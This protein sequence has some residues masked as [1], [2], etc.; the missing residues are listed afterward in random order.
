MEG[1][2]RI[3]DT[4]YFLSIT[5]QA[6]L[7]NHWTPVLESVVGSLGLQVGVES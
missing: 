5:Y 6:L 2:I 3:G 1:V 4:N 7:E